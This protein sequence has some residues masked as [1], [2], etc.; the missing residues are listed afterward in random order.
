VGGTSVAS[1][2]IASVYALA[3]NLTAGSYPASYAYAHP[4]DLNDVTL[5]SNG[6]CP[7]H[8]FRCN[9]E[10]GYDGPTGLGTPEGVG[11]FTG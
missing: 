5:G 11:A 2:I 1:P 9:G 8:L 6:S 4:G 3:D 7:E 10:V